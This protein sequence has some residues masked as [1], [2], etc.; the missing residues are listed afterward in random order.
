MSHFF[1]KALL[2]FVT[3]TICGAVVVALINGFVIVTAASN[4]KSSIDEL[5]NAQTVIILGAGVTSQGELSPIFKDRV[6]TAVAVYV[7]GK[8]GKILVSGDNSSL[9]Y[10][11]VV[12]VQEYLVQLGIPSEDIFL[13]YAGFDTYDTMYR[14]RA[15]FAVDS[16]IV[17]TQAFH[18]PR[19]VFLADVLGIEVEG[20][21]A[22]NDRTS[23]RNFWRE[24]AAR[25]K[26]ILDIMIK[27][28][29]TYL[30]EPIPITGDGRSTLSE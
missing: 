24:A 29:P 28:T 7:V 6:D 10:N 5:H 11:E 20:I 22:S 18:L 2:Y 1:S 16:A 15:V 25:V 14:A 21:P 12:P 4:I 3:I 19:A 30:G 9:A 13:D 27:S 23:T 17:V 26:A 8:V